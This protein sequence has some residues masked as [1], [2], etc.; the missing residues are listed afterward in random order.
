MPKVADI[1]VEKKAG[2][3]VKQYIGGGAPALVLMGIRHSNMAK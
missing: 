2:R 1:I 3:T